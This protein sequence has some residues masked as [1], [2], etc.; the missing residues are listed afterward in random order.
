MDEVFYYKT[1]ISKSP[2]RSYFTYKSV[3]EIFPGSRVLV[4]FSGK[5]TIA[6]VVEPVTELDVPDFKIKEIE[7]IIDAIPL[8]DE[9]NMKV[10]FEIINHYINPPGKVFDLF[11]SASPK[12]RIKQN[13]VRFDT[14]SELN[15][16]EDFE[17]SVSLEKFLERNGKRG[18]KTLKEYV[19][20][21]KA[22]LSWG[23]NK[24]QNKERKIAYDLNTEL[25]EIFDT[26]LGDTAGTII[27][28]LL[29][30]GISTYETL[31][32]KLK[33]K[34]KS[35]LNS[36]IKKGFVKT[37]EI[38]EER[39]PDIFFE[40][41]NILTSKQRDV[42]AD[43]VNAIKNDDFLH[44][45]HG[46]T[47]SGKTEI[48]FEL[49]N[50]SLS[51]G[52]SA[53]FLL[54]E[55]S[56]TP[57]L[58]QRVKSR[59]VAFNVEVF[60]SMLTNRERER[61]WMKI[62]TGDID[63]L[64]GT[65]S[66]LWLPLKNPGIIIMDEEHDESYMQSETTPVYDA[67]YTARFISQTYKI[68][69][70]M[71]SATPRIET[72]FSA[73]NGE[74]CLHSLTERP[75]GSKLPKVEIVDMKKDEK[76]NS[77][78]SGKLIREMDSF[79]KENNQ[80]FI[81]VGNKGYSSYAFCQ[82]CNYIFRC[83]NCDVSMTR[84]LNSNLLKCHYCG[85]EVETPSICPE[86]GSDNIAFRGFGTEKVEHLFSKLFPS[87]SVLRVDR[88]SITSYAELEK[89]F[90]TIKTRHIDIV[91]G[92]KMISKGLDFPDVNMVGIVNA[93]QLLYFPDF[94]SNE[95]TFQLISQMSGRAGRNKKDSIVIIQTTSTDSYPIICTVN[96]DYRAFYEIEIK[97]REEANYPPF[98]QLIIITVQSNDLGDANSLA[99]AIKKRIE[100]K[101]GKTDK[102]K[103]MGPVQPL[104]PK[105]MKSY[106]FN[107]L[108]KNKN[109]EKVLEII[110]EAVEMETNSEKNVKI[111]VDPIKMII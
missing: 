103:I 63:I 58:I 106:R 6:Y 104:I 60:H 7:E 102:I 83:I 79:L 94:R 4:N 78:L 17:T 32:D 14:T 97:Q 43:I 74:T 66:A 65:R 11:F 91:V 35:T 38:D 92:T 108:I 89:A 54:P 34:S 64:L 107:I 1:A 26:K 9:N 75:M 84:H 110:R 19:D 16:F 41:V 18:R 44:L 86:C 45:I 105:V 85:Y 90:E 47:G 46:I 76:L 42:Y 30:N 24:K 12:I 96:H 2:L 10:A 23:L 50:D 53:I 70:I 71:G 56:L 28:F 93:D 81:L 48:Y 15:G 25:R 22:E 49:M 82:N 95:R 21:G 62:L 111:I 33:I 87:K 20:S 37:F 40:S 61:V 69:L 39:D 31:R 3:V 99:D 88:E 55:I 73:K 100:S 5:L 98:S 27:D 72:Y 80:I 67:H 77:M 36:L 101:V 13:V 57:Q 51:K 8:I 109:H 59:F 68:P 52:L 29:F